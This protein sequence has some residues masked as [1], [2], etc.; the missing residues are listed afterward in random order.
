MLNVK[1]FKAKTVDQMARELSDEI[2]QNSVS[3]KTTNKAGHIDLKGRA[4]I[5]KSTGESIPTPHVQTYELHRGPNGKLSIS[6]KSEI[7]QPATKTDIRIARR[8]AEQQ[9]LLNKIIEENELDNSIT[10]G[11]T[12]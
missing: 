1:A 5:D 4:H 9:G 6:R 3:F 10:R 8:L 11:M 7:I 2:N 12:P